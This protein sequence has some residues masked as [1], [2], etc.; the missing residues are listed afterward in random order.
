VEG[1]L[2]RSA[3][4]RKTV[5][6]LFADL[7]AF[8]QLADRLDPEALRGLMSEFFARASAVVERLGGVVE[9]F[10]GD[11]VMSLFGV[12][13]VRED[14]ALRAVRAAIAMRDCVAELDREVEAHLEVR[15]GLNTGEVMTGDA[16]LGHTVSGEP[17]AL[18]K[19]LE[20]AAGPGEILLGESTYRLVAHA[21]RASQVG[22]LTLKG[23]SEKVTAYRLDSV[24]PQAI[25]IPRRGDTP[26][27]GHLRE[28]E[29]LRGRF[30]GVAAG[31]GAQMATVIGE[32]GI[33]KSRLAAEL[34][35][36][37]GE[38]AITL[39]GR[40]PPHG[41]GV[42]FSPVREVFREAGRDEAE[43]EG[44]SFEVFAAVRRLL[45]E[46]S[47]TRPVVIVFDDLHWAEETLL[48][49][50]EYL[51]QRLGP[52]PVLILCLARAELV[53]RRPQWVRDPASS[54]VL[55]PLSESESL[56]VLDALGAP[57]QQRPRIAELA[58]GNPLFIEQLAL[59]A[60]EDDAS[61][62]LVDSI[63]GVLHARLDRLDSQPRAVLER[64][65]VIGRRFALRAVLE[66]VEVGE[67]DVAQARLF[68]LARQGLIRPDVSIRDEGFRF[69]HA[70]VRDAVYEA[71]PKSLRADL[72][73]MVAARLEDEGE[74]DSV[75]GY[76]LERAYQ[77]RRE[78]GRRDL[79]LGRR[80]GRLLLRAGREVL[81]RSDLPAGIALLERARVLLGSDDR[82]L[83]SVLTELGDAHVKA[84]NMTAAERVLD[85]A[86]EVA[87]RIGARAAELHARVERQFVREFTSRS[88]SAHESVD[89]AQAAI[90]ELEGLGD[91]LALARAW[92]LRSSDDLAAARWLD[93][94]E[95]IERALAHARQTEAGLVMV[96][97][98]GGLLSQALLHGPTHV[99]EAIPRVERLPVELELEGPLRVAIDAALA[100]L[101]ATTGRIQDARRLYRDSIATAE[102]FGLRLRRAVQAI[103]GAQIELLAGDPAAAEQE[104][105]ASSQALDQFG[106]STSAA[107][108]RAVLAEVLCAAG[109]AEEAEAQARVVA[110]EVTED[111]LIT[112]VLWRTALA[113][114]LARRGESAKAATPAQE[115]LAL[116]AGMQFPFVQVAAL[117]A[118]AEA[119]PRESGRHL[120]AAR[121]ILDAKGNGVELARLSLLAPD[122]A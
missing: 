68:E 94:A 4:G 87:A 10:I 91:H 3:E 60:R 101:L 76:H 117:T 57:Q 36:V 111:D 55:D 32:P 78:L 119:A 65:A 109:Q 52:A 113:R 34:L 53:D 41:E 95:S 105:R 66:M 44:S 18:G 51:A 6:V 82:E 110:A 15:I 96:G 48:D 83:P 23:K 14:D 50:L 120:E 17:I 118:A 97:T 90:T 71:M 88:A 58:E 7:V 121:R 104:L 99:D 42:T 39:V 26:F 63:R 106:A 35:R 45:E 54:L 27:S 75:R 37:V 112:Q 56:L 13:L 72:H 11:E 49:L 29:W 67:R 30:G 40:C 103:I 81:G 92:W 98:L 33:G 114:A 85:E 46:L 79:E 59:F 19:R 8:T 64:A 108:H 102:E 5:T 107:T 100:G 86:I 116:S 62:T 61:V 43:L 73:L 77:L 22:P 74:P 2:S 47:E 84:G 89:I 38:E 70:L 24:D 9:K 80:A 93:R 21:V 69:Q 31:E 115:A 122:L 1:G 12:P 25:A 16:A 28:L 20:T